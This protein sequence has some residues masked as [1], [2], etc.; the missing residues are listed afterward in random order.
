MKGGIRSRLLIYSKVQGN[1]MQKIFY[2][3]YRMP[4]TIHIFFAIASIAAATMTAVKPTDK[5]F[6]ATYILSAGAVITGVILLLMN[7]GHFESV[8]VSGLLYVGSIATLLRVGR[9]RLA[10]PKSA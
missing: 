10:P 5:S 6:L 7:P 9:R 4:V 1:M 3:K 2:E 8:C